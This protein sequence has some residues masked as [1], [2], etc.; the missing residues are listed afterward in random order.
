[1]IKPCVRIMSGCTL[2]DNKSVEVYEVV[3][4]LEQR[5]LDFRD[6]T[7]FRECNNSEINA[8]MTELHMKNGQ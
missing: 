5:C 6:V 1:M 2:L 3:I 4:K 8:R 7:K